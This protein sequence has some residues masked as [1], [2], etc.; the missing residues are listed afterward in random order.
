MEME[1][2]VYKKKGQIM[3][4]VQA[5]IYLIIGVAVATLI[6]I[7]T[8]T[9]SGQTYQ[10]VEPQ[11]N[12]ITNTTIQGYVKSAAIAGFQAQSTTASYIPLIVLAI[13]IAIVLVTV[14]SYS[15]FGGMGGNRGSAL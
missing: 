1:K 11:I 14:L 15:S 8:T 12:A 5:M 6:I 2:S 3:G 9:L 4:S 7:F 10:L 13:I